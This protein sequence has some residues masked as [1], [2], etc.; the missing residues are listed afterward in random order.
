MKPV[1]TILFAVLALT[2]VYSATQVLGGIQPP[3]SPPE[4]RPEPFP[5]T[6]PPATLCV[7]C[8]KPSEMGGKAFPTRQK[9]NLKSLEERLNALYPRR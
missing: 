1:K 7:T 8:G 9:E 2:A 6:P 4:E 3:P 5:E